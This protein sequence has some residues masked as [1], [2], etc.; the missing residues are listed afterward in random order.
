[1]NPTDTAGTLLESLLT[2]ARQWACD[3]AEDQDQLEAINRADTPRE[4]LT[5][6]QNSN[7]VPSHLASAIADALV[8]L[9]PAAY[10]PSPHQR[11]LE[12]P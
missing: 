2:E 8:A 12:P 10:S 7:L 3:D 9:D 4:Q 11:R 6:L 5:L 1:M